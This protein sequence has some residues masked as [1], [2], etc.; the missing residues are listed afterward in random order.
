MG[1]WKAVRRSPSQRIELYNLAE[2]IGE[3]TDLAAKNPVMVKK[4]GEILSTAR[5]DSEFWPVKV[6]TPA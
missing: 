3:T 4:L 1:D 2:D 5:T 6:R